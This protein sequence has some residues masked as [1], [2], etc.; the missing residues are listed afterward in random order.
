M[1]A[2]RAFQRSADRWEWKWAG[3][4]L[5]LIWPHT[6]DPVMTLGCLHANTLAYIK[7]PAYK[8]R[9]TQSPE[10][11]RGI[12]SFIYSLLLTANNWKRTSL[13]PLPP[14]D[15]LASGF[16]LIS[17]SEDNNGMRRGIHWP[18]LNGFNI[19]SI[20][21]CLHN[22]PEPSFTLHSVRWLVALPSLLRDSFFFFFFFTVN[23][24]KHLTLKVKESFLQ[25]QSSFLTTFMLIGGV[26]MWMITRKV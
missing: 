1:S 20:K 3:R 10:R 19:H 22:S 13:C 14:I 26:N 11:E 7:A 21:K 15:W 16:G 24:Q 4:E 25:F 5:I 17:S 23:A 12:F 6:A 8:C 2:F 9:Q 18:Q